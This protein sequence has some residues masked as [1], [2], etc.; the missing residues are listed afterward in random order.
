MTRLPRSHVALA[1]ALLATLSAGCGIA[2]RDGQFLCP[3]GR[4]PAG[5]SC[6]ADGVCHVG[7]GTDAG[8]RD[9][10]GLDAPGLDA[11]GL[12]AP[13]LDAPGLD[14]PD[15]GP[16]ELCA[17]AAATDAPADEDLDGWIDEGCTLALGEIHPVLSAMP[18]RS[19]YDGL[20]L[21]NDGLSGVVVDANDTP[22]RPILV[23][24][25]PDV[26]SPFINA[27]PLLGARDAALAPF[28]VTVDGAGT[29]L[30]VQARD[31]GGGM[32]LYSAF[33]SVAGG[34]FSGLTRIAALDAFGIRQL[35]PSLS[36]DGLELFFVSQASDG[37]PTIHHARRAALGAAWMTVVNLGRGLYPRPSPDG[38]TLHFVDVDAVVTRTIERASP[39]DP[40]GSL[41]A[42]VEWS[43]IGSRGLVLLPSFHVATRE[44]FFTLGSTTPGAD[45]SDAPLPYSIFRA[46]VCADGACVPERIPC[47]DGTASA[48]GL[49]CYRALGPMTSTWVAAFGTCDGPGLGHMITIHTADE[50]ALARGVGLNYWLGMTGTTWVTNE[51]TIFTAFA[52]GS[53]PTGTQC[54]VEATA[55]WTVQP[56]LG[57]AIP[58][59]EEEI[60]PTFVRR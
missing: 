37:S 20:E 52:T 38:R 6:G 2:A 24:R 60:W 19:V 26:L 5:L 14:A 44:V 4:C 8:A 30:V 43:P 11:P 36:R 51:P 10:P 57:A 53:M 16:I 9:A 41:T 28:L 34:S 46:E 27:A 23:V 55:G 31:A 59:C 13:G 32:H 39:D 22:N 1:S 15:G 33:G 35:H 25:R 48:D 29:E 7:A 18:T 45:R 21:V 58:L 54:S 42:G 49:H 50:L 17:P 47:V 12:D 40:F 56:C 3:D